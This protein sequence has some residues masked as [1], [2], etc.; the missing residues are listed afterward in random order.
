[1]RKL[2]DVVVKDCKL[3]KDWKR[4]VGVETIPK[5]G[6]VISFPADQNLRHLNDKDRA[7]NLLSKKS[8][9]SQSSI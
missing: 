3:D 8:I 9:A 6:R 1:M 4:L 5:L 2:L 7:I